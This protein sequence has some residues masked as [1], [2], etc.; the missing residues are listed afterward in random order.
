M[1]LKEVVL[2]DHDN[3]TYRN[4]YFF[5]L[6]LLLKIFSYKLLQFEALILYGDK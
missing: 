5:I 1:N 2:S 6:N 4:N 3:F